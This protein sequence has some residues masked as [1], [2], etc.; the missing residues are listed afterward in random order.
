MTDTA[1][2]ISLLLENVRSV[3]SHS[4]FTYIDAFYYIFL[5]LFNARVDLKP[6]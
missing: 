2:L 6:R 5:L 4:I 3:K 1:L